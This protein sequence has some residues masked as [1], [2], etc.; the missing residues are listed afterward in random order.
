MDK[1]TQRESAQREWDLKAFELFHAMKDKDPTLEE[2]RK[3]IY[4]RLGPRP[5]T[6][7]IEELPGTIEILRKLS[8][9]RGWHRLHCSQETVLRIWALEYA[10]I[11]FRDSGWYDMKLTRKGRKVLR[12]LATTNEE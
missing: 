5:E 10:Q 12:D 4:I 2:L 6:R 8:K 1:V 9:R 7:S 3:R 11:E